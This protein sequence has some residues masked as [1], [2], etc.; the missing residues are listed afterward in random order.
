MSIDQT[1]A[2]DKSVLPAFK[3]REDFDDSLQ[4]SLDDKAFGCKGLTEIIAMPSSVSKPEISVSKSP[5]SEP[6]FPSDP[7][8]EKIDEIEDAVRNIDQP[9][10]EDLGDVLEEVFDQGPGKLR[11]FN[12]SKPLEQYDEYATKR[13][14]KDL[15]RMKL[16]EEELGLLEKAKEKLSADFNFDETCARAQIEAE[17]AYNKI[18]LQIVKKQVEVYQGLDLIVSQVKEELSTLEEKEQILTENERNA[19]EEEAK[20]SEA[21]AATELLKKEQQELRRLE[22]EENQLDQNL[23]SLQLQVT[24]LILDLGSS[25]IIYVVYP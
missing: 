1:D 10:F 8:R 16:S 12:L 5:E 21:K 24:H 25:H 3:T 18:R 6:E 14:L 19:Q 4:N 20:R 9:T 11:H 23:A 17:L 7:V 15:N 2:I 13:L 22:Q